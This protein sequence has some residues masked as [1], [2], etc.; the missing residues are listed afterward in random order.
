[1]DEHLSLELREAAAP[2]PDGADRERVV[3]DLETNLLVEA[4]AG[5]GKT[6]ALVGRMVALVRTGAGH[7]REI[8]AVTFTRKA[9]AEL[10]ERFQ[11]ELES[12]VRAETDPDAAVRLRDGLHHIDQA[13][14]GTIHAFCASLLRERPIEAGL[15]PGFEEM[16][17]AENSR[18]MQRYWSTFLERTVSEEDPALEELAQ[19]GLSVHR[20]EWAYYGVSENL[21]VE[22]P[23]EEVPAPGSDEIGSVQARLDELLD[24]ARALLP[25]GEPVKGWDALQER[26]R[27]LLFARG[28]GWKDTAAMIAA[29]QDLCGKSKYGVTQNR[30]DP[31]GGRSPPAKVLGEDFTAFVE[32]DGAARR[33]LARWYAHRYPAVIR[34]VRRAAEGYADY[35]LA[36]GRLSFQDLLIQT[37]ALLRRSPRA[38]RDLGNRYRRILVDEFQDTDPVQAEVVFLL[39][40]DPAPD[41]APAP[42]WWS[43]VPRP[44]AL[45]VVGDPKQ[46]IYRFR[47]ADIGIYNQVKERF[48]TFGDVLELTA[49]FRS[50]PAVADI[51][52]DVF[53][54]GGLFPPEESAY[55]A[56]FAPLV[57]QPRDSPPREGV[58]TYRVSSPRAPDLIS[59]EADAL[60]DWIAAR[61]ESGERPPGDF[62]ILTRTKPSLAVY[63]RALED[64][65]LPVDVAGAGVGYQDVIGEL[66]AILEA[67]LDPDNDLFVVRCLMGLF[68]GIDPDALIDHKLA[69]GRWSF[70]HRPPEANTPVEQALARLHAWWQESRTLPADVFVTR[71]VGELG[72]FP[73]AAA[74]EL[75]SQRTGAL[76]YALDAVRAQAVAGDTSLLGALEA[77]QGAIDWDDAEAPLEPGRSDAVRVMNL[78]KVKGLQAP[79]VVLAQPTGRPKLGRR[80]LKVERRTGRSPEGW[81]S[82]EETVGTGRG[83]RTVTLAAPESWEQKRAD[84]LAYEEAEEDRLL[85]V[86]VTRARD[87]LVVSQREGATA[88]S[89]SPWDRLEPWLNEHATVLELEAGPPRDR[90]RLERTAADL[91]AEVARV[92]TDRSGRAGATYRFESVTAV[93]KGSD[94]DDAGEVPR[95]P[96]GA[97]PG[98]G[99]TEPRAAAGPAPRGYEWGSVVHAAL[100]AAARGLAMDS[101]REVCRSLLVEQERPVDDTGHPRELEELVTLVERVRASDLWSRSMR[102]PVRH[103]EIPFA[104]PRPRSDDPVPEWIEGVIDLVF[105][106]DGGWV[107]ADYKTDVG[108]DPDFPRRSQ[109]YRRQVDLYAACWEALTDEPVRE[110]VLLFTAQD[111][112]ERW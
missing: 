88:R 92:D 14:I 6:T 89:R 35:R 42:P 33:L 94:P 65:G 105:E 23:A 109:A 103:A 39:A 63:A 85:Y 72:L 73:H 21:D 56:P 70:A 98:R 18:L 76:V 52:N 91:L 61:V 79:V 97:L 34:F 7:P 51:V 71:L 104:A 81:V 11:N 106:E 24:R 77:L 19:L 53:G 27:R 9:A 102:A 99:S 26:A 44:G 29:I 96:R 67:L 50:R 46:S 37:A 30:W 20:L 13:F 60:A 3:T 10:R 8:A 111:R 87:E 75:G 45:F 57:A 62:M 54:D 31:A 80:N 93:A 110:R 49:N 32:P 28:R 22:F 5:S 36:T 58:F 16:L 43:L 48:R 101:L 55:Q 17:E 84:E 100:A 69:R 64:R 47:R 25:T 90:G 86:A 59:T 2:L 112:E 107:I 40:S 108:D 66:L 68:F 95:S 38:R 4:G 82:I 83:K 74:G 15:D 1:M 41:G 78:H 12:A